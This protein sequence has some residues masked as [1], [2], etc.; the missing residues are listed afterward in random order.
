MYGLNETQRARIATLRETGDQS[1]APHARAVDT[2]GRFPREAIDALAAGGWFGLNVPAAQG[3]LG[4][5][6]RIAAAALEEIAQ[7]CAS[8]A[9]VYLMHLCGCAAYAASNGAADAQLRD[10]ARGAHLATLAWSETGSRSHFWAPVSR[11]GMRD[12]H[13]VLNATKSFVTSAGVADG[14]V[15]STGASTGGGPSDSTLYLVLKDDGGLRISRGFDGLGLRGNASAAMTLADCV[16]PASR[17]LTAEGQGFPRMLEILPWFN[18][19]N[20]AVSMGI[21]ASAVAATVAHLTSARYEHLGVRLVDRAELRDRVARMQMQ[22]DRARALIAAALDALEDG[23]P[24]ALLLVLES[25]AVASEAAAAVTELGM[26]ACGGAAYA[27]RVPVERAFRDARAARI[28]AP[29]TDALTDFV[30]RA[31]CGL[32]LFG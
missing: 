5:G 17:A 7:R 14:Y 29:T 8:T 26:E 32:E 2:E 4:E 18:L 19:G 23:A 22:T 16:I 1:I 31:V 15:V 27:K 11:A 12:G 25:K 9:M 24:N 10:A 30:G 13:V 21:A 28:M 6:M 20:A 3:G